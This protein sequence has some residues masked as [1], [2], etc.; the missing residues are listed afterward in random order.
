MY[1]MLVYSEIVTR[2]HQRYYLY[3]EPPMPH[4]HTLIF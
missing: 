1:V 2:A 3:V 4:T